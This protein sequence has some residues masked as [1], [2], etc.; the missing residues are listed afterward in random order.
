LE[1]AL[2][3]AIIFCRQPTGL[4]P[5]KRPTINAQLPLITSELIEIVVRP[6]RS[7]NLPITS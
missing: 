7:A 5:Y 3:Q 2:N 4:P 6:K 1:E